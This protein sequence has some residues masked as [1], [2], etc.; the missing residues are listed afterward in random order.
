MTDDKRCRTDLNGGLLPE[1]N[2]FN[3]L[4]IMMGGLLTRLSTVNS[5]FLDKLKSD[6]LY[7][8]PSH[9]LSNILSVSSDRPVYCCEQY[10]VVILIIL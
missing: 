7:E 10:T 1:L 8:I 9:R 2:L 6:L 3:K 4:L 5:L